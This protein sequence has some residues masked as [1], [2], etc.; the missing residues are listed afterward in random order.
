LVQNHFL[1][2]FEQN[3]IKFLMIRESELILNNDGTI[4][5]LHLKPEQI[6]DSIILVGDPGRVKMIS[7]KFNSV[8]FTITN[9]EF[10][11]ATGI[12][13]GERMTVLSTGIGTDNIDI[14]LN[15]LDA[16]VNIDLKRRE[17]KEKHHSLRLVRIGTSGGLQPDIPVNSWIVSRKSIGFDSTLAWY[18][19]LPKVSD[20][21][22]ESAFKS[23]LHWPAHFPSPYVVN[24][25]ESLL[26]KFSDPIYIHG[27]NISAP[28]FYGPQ[29]R[30]LRLALSDPL[31]NHKLGQFRFNDFRITNYEMESSALYGL[32]AM[33]GHQALTVCLLIANR[34][35]RNA[36]ENYQNKMEELVDRVLENLTVK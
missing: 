25:S 24:S 36:N 19:D 14:V 31:L 35:Q 12:Y 15:E 17:I 22:F 7:K 13:K 3:N 29:G 2:S 28:G 26:E 18:A 6:A 34:I 1:N 33:L 4:F 23:A 11:T 16:L 10:V 9:R 30:I 21:A 5:H 20:H 32:S 8:E 27:V